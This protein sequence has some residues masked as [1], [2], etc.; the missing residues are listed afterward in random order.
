ME[1]QLLSEL[2]DKIK[3]Y[4]AYEKKIST[5]LRRSF[6]FGLIDFPIVAINFLISMGN[7]LVDLSKLLFRHPKR[8][9]KKPSWLINPKSHNGKLFRLLPPYETFS[10]KSKYKSFKRI[11]IVPITHNYSSRMHFME[12]G[13]NKGILSEILT[14]W[15]KIPNLFEYIISVPCWLLGIQFLGLD[16]KTVFAL[17]RDREIYQSFQLRGQPWLIR[18]CYKVKWL[19][20]D[21][22]PWMYTIEFIV[23]GLIVYL[24]ILFIIE[25]ISAQFIYYDGIEKKL[26][27]A[28][29]DIA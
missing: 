16:P 29:Y 24:F 1:D 4:F 21:D 13:K 12:F 18:V 9:E 28:I 3:K 6:I 27:R 10:Y 22:V 11:V 17:C 26:S 23:V 8:L 5:V 20:F 7:V 2:E 19:V 15:E 25:F 14:R